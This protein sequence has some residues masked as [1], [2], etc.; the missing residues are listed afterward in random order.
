MDPTKLSFF[1]NLLLS[2]I[3]FLTIVSCK[4]DP[5]VTADHYDFVFGVYNFSWSTYVDLYAVRNGKV[6][7]VNKNDYKGSD[8]FTFSDK[9]LSQDRY[10]ISHKLRNKFPEYLRNSTQNVFGCPGCGDQST[11]YVELTENGKKRSWQLDEGNNGQKDVDEFA[12]EI[13]KT[14]ELLK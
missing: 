6:Y 4:K 1:K 8:E 5:E 14:L 2:G 3:I 11:I 12:G 9:P 13:K 7:P 10:I